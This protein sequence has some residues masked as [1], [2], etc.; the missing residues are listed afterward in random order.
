M[1]DADESGQACAQECYQK[2]GTK[3][4]IKNIEIGEFGKKP[5]QLEQGIIK[6][7]LGR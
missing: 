1:F 6:E 2:L 7:L 3:L 5:H 4:F